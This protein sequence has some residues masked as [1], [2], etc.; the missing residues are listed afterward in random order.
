MK[1]IR[2]ET[3]YSYLKRV[4]YEISEKSKEIS[5]EKEKTEYLKKILSSFNRL[6]EKEKMAVISKVLEELSYRNVIFDTDFLLEHENVKLRSR[7]FNTIFISIVI[8]V[9]AFVFSDLFYQIK[10]KLGKIY[11]LLEEL[12]KEGQ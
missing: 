1:P 3:K 2:Q 6:N 10:I 7:L 4:L 5:S 9:I 11:I 8:L 12:F